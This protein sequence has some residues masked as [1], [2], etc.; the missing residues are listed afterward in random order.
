MIVLGDIHK[1]RARLSG[2]IPFLRNVLESKNLPTEFK[3]V[4]AIR[5]AMKQL[6]ALTKPVKE[7]T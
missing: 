5:R 7:I 4:I 2:N 6:N 3:E 1:N